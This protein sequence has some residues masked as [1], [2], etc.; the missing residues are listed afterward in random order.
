MAEE[1]VF[2]EVGDSGFRYNA[3]LCR[4]GLRTLPGV[5]L[6]KEKGHNFQKEVG[7]GGVSGGQV[8]VGGPAEM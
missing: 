7:V 3:A 6:E 1:S 8:G 5:R 4:L 2:P